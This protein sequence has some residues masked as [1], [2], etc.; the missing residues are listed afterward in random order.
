MVK[1][2]RSLRWG[3]GLA[4]QAS[5]VMHVVPGF[6]KVLC[7]LQLWLNRNWH[8]LLIDGY[9][10]FSRM[11]SK[12]WEST[13][14]LRDEHFASFG[15]RSFLWWFSWY[16]SSWNAL[17]HMRGLWFI[18]WRLCS[19]WVGYSPASHWMY[20]HRVSVVSY[21]SHPSAIHLVTSLHMYSGILLHTCGSC[22]WFQSWYCGML[23]LCLSLIPHIQMYGWQQS[24]TF[25]FTFILSV[26]YQS[27]LLNLW[28]DR[29]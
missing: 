22:S 26:G 13:P 18:T 28:E 20:Q 9:V 16:A 29:K 2:T 4:Y 12:A 21:F 14:F 5:P 25:R 8:K 19:A 15:W 24:V 10:S 11:C 7:S 23:Q 1:K 3:T 6:S 27:D 17:R